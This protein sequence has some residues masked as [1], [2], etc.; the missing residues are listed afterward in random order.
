[1]SILTCPIC[2]SADTSSPVERCKTYII[3][4]CPICHGDFSE[5]SLSVDYNYEYQA[6]ELSLKRLMRSEDDL[7][8]ARSLAHYTQALEYIRTLRWRGSLLNLTRSTGVFSRLAEE[9]GFQVNTLCSILGAAKYAEEG[10]GLRNVATGTI[11]DIPSDWGNFNV[12]TCFEVLEHVAQPRNLAKRVFELLS[13]GGLF[14][15]SA[16]NRQ[17]LSVVMGRRDAHD[18]PPNH[19]T[20]WSKDVLRSFLDQLGYTRITIKIDGIE[21]R[22]LSAILFPRKLNE[23]IVKSKISGLSNGESDKRHFFIHSYLWRLAQLS[24]DTVATSLRFALGG[25]YGTFL[26]GF[27]QRP[28]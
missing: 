10:F 26:V 16:P 4:R 11:D 8:E 19:L 22:D 3:Y 5:T 9:A 13:P 18:Y 25:H 24:G 7:K 2:G 28:G 23:Q 6:G 14:I 1:M 15:A 27:G 21:R 12:I 17:R 20:R